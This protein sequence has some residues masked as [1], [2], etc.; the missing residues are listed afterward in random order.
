M[1]AIEKFAQTKKL[2]EDFFDDLII[3]LS[4]NIDFKRLHVILK[5]GIEIFIVFNN[6]N[7]YSYSILFSKLELD[8]CKF[9]NFD[10]LWDVPT[11]PHHFHPRYK[12]QAIQSDMTGNPNQDIPLLYKL[13]KSGKLY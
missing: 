3:F 11:R 6:H 2:I 10:K 5:D 7:E 1:S 4:L 13:L 9:D 8:R 12:K